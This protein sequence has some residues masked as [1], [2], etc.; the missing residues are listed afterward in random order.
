MSDTSDAHGRCLCGGIRYAVHGELGDVINCHCERCRQFTGH[1]MAATSVRLQ[2]LY[3]EDAD[4]LLRWFFP[5]PEAGYAFC[6]RCG[7]SL[8]WQSKAEPASRSIC[9]GTLHTPTGLRT[10]QAWWTSQASDYHNRPDLPEL[11]TE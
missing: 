8:F 10:T 3:I 7:S 9:A 5:V 6:S 1:H 2:D 4:S 11:A